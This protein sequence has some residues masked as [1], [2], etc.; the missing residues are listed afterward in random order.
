[1]SSRHPNYRLVKIHRNYSVEEIAKLFS[2]HRNTVRQWIK[3][4]LPTIDRKRPMLIHGHDLAE[5]L[6]ARRS[7]NKQTCRPGQIYCVR[8]RA[9][10]DPAGGMAEYKPKNDTLGSLIG[11]CPVC[12]SMMY[13]HVNVARLDQIRGQLEITMVK[14]AR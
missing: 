9:P 4:G 3:Q 10:R 8:C 6:Q 13:R 7:K 1:M 12:E 14:A 5:F 2:V 11:I